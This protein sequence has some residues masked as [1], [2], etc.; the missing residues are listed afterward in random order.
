MVEKSS[1]N[2]ISIERQDRAI[3]KG[4]YLLEDTEE[5]Y[6][7]L[8]CFGKWLHLGKSSWKYEGATSDIRYATTW[9]YKNKAV[10]VEIVKGIQDD[11]I[12]P[13]YLKCAIVAEVYRSI[14]NGEVTKLTELN[15]DLLMKNSNDKKMMNCK[16][17]VD[18][19]I[20]TL[21]NII[22]PYDKVKDNLNTIQSY[23]NLIQGKNKNA[24]RK[25]IK[26]T[27][28]DVVFKTIKKELFQLNDKDFVE[29]NIKERNISKQYVEK[30]LSRLE[31]VAHDEIVAAKLA[32]KKV[33][34]YFDFPEG[35]DIESEDIKELLNEAQDFYKDAETNGV[36]ISIR[37]DVVVD[38]KK[39]TNLITQSLHILNENYNGKS[40]L[41]VLLAFSQNPM[42]IVNDFINLLDNIKSDM[43]KVYSDLEQEK[44]KLTRSGN[45]SADVDPRFEEYQKEFVEIIQLLEV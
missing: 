42:K 27:E 1:L 30:I 37:S 33:N 24:K 45:W 11:E 2:L 31:K 41:E 38:M 28:L 36:N 23:F 4:L 29:E 43:E 5:T 25:I 40:V 12:Y 35:I 17:H 39:K 21:E 16:G 32:Y 44:N 8:M 3:E 14:L 18:S 9:L 34:E 19:W 13:S 20:E 26:A 7:L 15:V 6:Q 22:Y 10:F